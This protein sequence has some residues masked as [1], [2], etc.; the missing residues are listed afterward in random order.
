MS[1]IDMPTA[2]HVA[3]QR[4]GW[5]LAA[6]TA[7]FVGLCALTNPYASPLPTCP[8]R[9]LTG[10]PCPGCG[11]MRAFHSITRGNLSAAVSMNAFSLLLLVAMILLLAASF[12]SAR[13]HSSKCPLPLWVRASTATGLWAT[14]GVGFLLFGFIRAVGIVPWPPG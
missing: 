8:F 10:V 14:L 13:A 4:A 1:S 7:G 2:S 3:P 6:V 12:Y 11:T 5:P 9:A